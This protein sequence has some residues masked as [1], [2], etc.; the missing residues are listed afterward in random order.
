MKKSRKKMLLSSIAML[1]VA[2]VALGS[3]TFA[4]Y[5]TNTEV[6]ASPTQFK[7]ASSDGLVI[8]HEVGDAW[9]KSI[10]TL[11]GAPAGGLMPASI[12]YNDAF[13]AVDG[14]TAQGSDFDDGSYKANTYKN[15]S[16]TS[17][18]TNTTNYVVDSFFVGSQGASAK[19]ATFTITASGVQGTYMNLAIYVGGVLQKV[20]VSDTTSTSVTNRVA[21]QNNATPT[22]FGTSEDKKVA[23]LAD[24]TV[25]TSFSAGAIGNDLDAETGTRVDIIAFPDGENPNCKSSNVKLDN[26]SV[27]YTFRTSA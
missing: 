25:T 3:A 7:A 2:L 9:A 4:W 16:H 11:K 26:F 20:Y 27:T 13:D 6:T 10:D 24:G 12:D 22:T 1:L 5:V 23:P 19:T 21:I 18:M 14:C 8:R 17:L 15:I